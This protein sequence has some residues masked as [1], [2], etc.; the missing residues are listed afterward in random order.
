MIFEIKKLDGILNKFNITISQLYILNCIYCK[1]IQAIKNHIDKNVD[2]FL[3]DLKYLESL[4][5][6]EYHGRDIEN[7]D[8]FDYALTESFINQ[9]YLDVDKAGN[10]FFNAYPSYIE[11]NGNKI[12]AKKGD[13]DALIEQ[14]CKDINYDIEK[15]N[16]ILKAIPIAIAQGSL[17]M[18]IRNFI[19]SKLYDDLLK[20]VDSDTNIEFREMI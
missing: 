10:E 4:S 3:N 12:L 9:M 8:F 5:Y 14:Y 19:E 11:I 1:E 6:L 16:K 20:L 13:R 15:H 7:I 18:A 17:N 2:T